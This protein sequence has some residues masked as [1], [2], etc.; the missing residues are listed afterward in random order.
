M[1]IRDEPTTAYEEPT[2]EELPPL[3]EELQHM[4]FGE[5]MERSNRQFEEDRA[6]YLAE[7]AEAREERKR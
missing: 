1:D 6:E 2:T 3:A 7:R 4:S 5:F